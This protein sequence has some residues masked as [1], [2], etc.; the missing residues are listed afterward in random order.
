MA[1]WVDRYESLSCRSSKTEAYS[2][3]V[4]FQLLF[5]ETCYFVAHR[6]GIFL[7]LDDRIVR[8]KGSWEFVNDTNESSVD[9]VGSPD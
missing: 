3:L 6:I 2:Y 1:S 8:I 5:G 4:V 9:V 7:D